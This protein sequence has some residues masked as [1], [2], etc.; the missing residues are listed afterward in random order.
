MEDTDSEKK[1]KIWL[2]YCEA[3]VKSKI[4][5]T[6]RSYCEEC[7]TLNKEEPLNS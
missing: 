3:C 4:G 7:C 5:N 1:A 2:K 6:D